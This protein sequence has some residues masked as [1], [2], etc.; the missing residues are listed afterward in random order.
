[1]P[2]TEYNYLAHHGVKGMKWGVR[3]Y[4]NYDGTLTSTGKER[5]S[6]DENVSKSLKKIY[7]KR[8][9]LQKDL[10]SLDKEGTASPVFKKRY[11]W[12]DTYTDEKF[13]REYGRTKEDAVKETKKAT[14]KKLLRLSYREKLKKGEDLTEEEA[15]LCR[16]D[17]IKK[18]L[19]V[20]AVTGVTVYAAYKSGA[21]D[22]IKEQIAIRNGSLPKKTRLSEILEQDPTAGEVDHIIHEGFDFYRMSGWKQEDFSEANKI[23]VSGTDTDRDTYKAFLKDFHHTGKRFEA[24]LR[25]TKDLKVAGSRSQKKMLKELLEDEDYFED[26]CQVIYKNYPDPVNRGR[27]FIDYAGKEAFMNEAYTHAIYNLHDKNSKAAKKFIDYAKQLGYDALTDDHDRGDNIAYNP[28]ILF[29]PAKNVKQVRSK[30][31]KAMDV[32]GAQTRTLKR[33]I[34]VN[35]K[36]PNNPHKRTKW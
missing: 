4:R 5:Y 10:D 22:T 26:L 15:K 35:P 34:A 16:E 29:D 33:G 1:M 18:A 31:V 11:L 24:A 30:K 8:E 7:E 20:A 32:L 36:L 3:R 13:L 14:E 2:Y 19:L 23:F 28:M 27:N 12:S 21:V 25:A 9:Q 17:N 6:S